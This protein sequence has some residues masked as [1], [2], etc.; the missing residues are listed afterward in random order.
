MNTLFFKPALSLISQIVEDEL[1]LTPA[2]ITSR[3]LTKSKNQTCKLTY[4]FVDN[5]SVYDLMN[6]N[7][8]ITTNIEERLVALGYEVDFI[9]MHIDRGLY[10]EFDTSK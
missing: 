5:N 2:Q 4:K 9:G 10:I 8:D 1:K 6:F 7:I 3:R